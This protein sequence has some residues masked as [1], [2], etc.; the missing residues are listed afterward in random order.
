MKKDTIIDI[1]SCLFI[2]LFLYTGVSKLLDFSRFSSTLERS[3]LL[4]SYASV[5]AIILPLVELM[6]VYLL[7]IPFFKITTRFRVHGLYAS[8][9]LMALFTLYIGYMLAFTPDRPCSCGGII[10]QMNWHQHLY[11]NS[12]FTLLAF[13]GILLSNKNKKRI[14][15]D[16]SLT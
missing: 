5:I 4:K 2:M 7:L 15:D 9:I 12:V 10:S 11:F 13:T 8:F 16:L 14:S 6:V 3:P 1:I